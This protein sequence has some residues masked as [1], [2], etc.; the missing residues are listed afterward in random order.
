VL[1]DIE[2]KYDIS[3]NRYKPPP[4]YKNWQEA[5]FENG[6]QIEVK[7]NFNVYPSEHFH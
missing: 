3:S 5:V 1:T 6:I 4:E 7:D 2:G